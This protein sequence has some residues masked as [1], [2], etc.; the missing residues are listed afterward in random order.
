MNQMIKRASALLL[1]GLMAL[2]AASCAKTPASSNTPSGASSGGT[3][4]EA[5]YADYAKNGTVPLTTE[6]V[7]LKILT[8]DDTTQAEHVSKLKIWD[9]MTKQTGVKVEIEEYTGDDLT[10]KLPLIMSSGTLPDVLQRLS[11]TS[12]DLLSYA[13]QDKII[14]LDDLVEQYGYYSKQLL[15]KYDYA[16]GAMSAADGHIYAL[17]QFSASGWTASYP[18]VNCDWLKNVGKEAPTT[19]EELYDVLKAFKEQDANG[20]GDPNDEIPMSASSLTGMGFQ[21]AWLGFVGIAEFW[22][23]SGATFDDH[24]GT[25]YMTRTSDNYRYLLSWLHKCYD[26]ELLDR[27]VFTHTSDEYKADYEANRIGLAGDTGVSQKYIDMGLHYD[28][29]TMSSKVS[30]KPVMGRGMKFNPNIYTV[31]ATCKTPELAF[32]FGDY[33]YSEDASW[34]IIKGVEGESF[35]WTDKANFQTKATE[36]G[37]KYEILT[38]TWARD[39]WASIPTLEESKKLAAA[40]APYWKDAWQHYMVF[41]QEETDQ[42]TMLSTDMATVIDES[43]VKFITGDMDVDSDDVWNK[44]VK[45]VTDLGLDDLTKVYQSAY[46][47]FYGKN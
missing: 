15:E 47:R 44:Y 42:I 17:P 18:T 4:S 29:L 39:N 24:D 12:G 25:V 1:A 38:N 7:T 11:L 2:S 28:Y 46:D 8:M 43:F 34:I 22:P 27:N 32:M 33:Y 9:W 23:I 36:T 30:P 13:A 5:K 3:A 6:D 45:Q 40:R 37:N 35:E 26:E 16:K 21:N 31:S 19:L 41:T 10:T 14:A 20:N